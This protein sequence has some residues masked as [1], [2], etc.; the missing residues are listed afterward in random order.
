MS[1]IHVYTFI[2]TYIHIYISMHIYT[3]IYI[4]TC[5][6]VYTHVYIHTHPNSFDLHIMRWVLFLLSFYVEETETHRGV[7][8]RMRPLPAIGVFRSI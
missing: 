8:F 3:H 5:I 2:D 1:Y 4:Y 7:Q 6:F